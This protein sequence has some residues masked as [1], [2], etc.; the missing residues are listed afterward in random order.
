MV[1]EQTASAI[2]NGIEAYPV[3]AEVNA[4]YED[5][6]IVIVGL[7]D[8]AVVLPRLG[9]RPSDRFGKADLLSIDN[10]EAP[11]FVVENH[12]LPV[13]ADHKV[14]RVRHDKGP[15]IAEHNPNRSKGLS[16]H[17]FFDLVCDHA[18]ESGRRPPAKANSFFLGFT[19]GHATINLGRADVRK[20]GPG[21]G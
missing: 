18:M 6:T 17:Q 19:L 13:G 4:G 15:L 8:A 16:V 20:E 5:T 14:I 11:L 7:P 21:T 2:L 3:E 1:G 12:G 10:L 9:C